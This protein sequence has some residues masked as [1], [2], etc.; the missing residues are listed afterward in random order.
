[1]DSFYKAMTDVPIIF[2]ERDGRSVVASKM[3]RQGC[4]A[5]QA[6]KQWNRSR[7]LTGY[8]VHGPATIHTL[9]FEELVS[10]PDVELARICKFLGIDYEPQM[11]DGTNS[12]VVPEDYRQHGFDKST[13]NVP[14]LPEFVINQ[15]RDGLEYAGYLETAECKS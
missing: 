7:D 5:G 4:V 14:N 2:I 1:M 15:I 9:K 10:T 11:L 3:R 12:T 13:L 8:L 6:C